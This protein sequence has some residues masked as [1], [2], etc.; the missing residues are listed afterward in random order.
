MIEVPSMQEVLKDIEGYIR[1]WDQLTPEEQFTLGR[2]LKWA[3]RKVRAEQN[4]R[5]AKP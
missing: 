5:R 3:W 1:N 2:E 4:A